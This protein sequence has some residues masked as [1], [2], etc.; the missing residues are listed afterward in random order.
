MLGHP[1]NCLST[2]TPGF[3][4]FPCSRHLGWLGVWALRAHLFLLFCC[5]M[6]P[7]RPCSLEPAAAKERCPLIGGLR[8]WL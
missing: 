8:P 6:Q 4:P 2:G 5:Q 1:L 7:L 3:L